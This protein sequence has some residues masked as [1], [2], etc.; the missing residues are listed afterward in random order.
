LS[1]LLLADD[2]CSALGFGAPSAGGAGVVPPGWRN[3]GFRSNNGLAEIRYLLTA[4]G[5]AAADS[6]LFLAKS[7]FLS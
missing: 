5:L 4:G 6:V 2:S 7:A 1:F 3:C